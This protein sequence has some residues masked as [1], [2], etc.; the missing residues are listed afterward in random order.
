MLLISAG[1]GATPVL[2]ML[3]ALAA[4]GPAGTSGGCMARGTGP[5]NRSP[6][7]HASLLAGLTHGH[8]HICYSHPGPADVAGDDY[9]RRAG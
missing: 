5:P 1:V 4:G 3:H 6:P 8:R 7:S 9:E 2:A